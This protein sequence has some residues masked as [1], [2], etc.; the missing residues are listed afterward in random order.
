MLCGLRCGL[1]AFASALLFC[2]GAQATPLSDYRQ[3]LAQL[4]RRPADAKAAVEQFASRFAAVGSKEQQTMANDLLL[5]YGLGAE[6]FDV[7]LKAAQALLA[8]E[9]NAAQRSALEKIAAQLSLRTKRYAQ[10]VSYVERWQS[11]RPPED[12]ESDKARQEMA[13]MQSLA[14]YALW[15]TADPKGSVAWMRQAYRSE[16]TKQRGNFL[17]GAWQRLGDKAAEEA[18]LP[19][20]IR[21]YGDAVY[22]SRYGY[23]LYERGQER[24]A[25]DVFSSAESSGRLSAELVPTL[26][27]LLLKNGAATKA[28]EV[29]IRHR[30]QLDPVLAQGLLVASLVD[31]GDRKGALSAALA[32]LPKG[33]DSK[34]HVRQAAAQLAFCEE[35]WPLAVRLAEEMADKEKR[36]ERAEHWLFMAGVAAFSM[37]DYARAE[38]CWGRIAGPKLRPVVEQWSKQAAF[39]QK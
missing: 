28:A 22:W 8:L 14:A 2:A 7:A 29:V 25:L 5:R 34:P 38:N 24:R 39:L 19:E 18:F 32:D 17:L 27:A 37:G 4:E 36:V 13:Q 12:A 21:R 10:T 23:L 15:E 11:H 30:E 9:P 31:S 26:A 20:M 16:P 33:A 1:A 3:I 6:D 35:N